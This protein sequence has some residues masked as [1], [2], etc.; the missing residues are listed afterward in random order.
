MKPKSIEPKTIELSRV[1]VEF[2]SFVQRHKER[3]MYPIGVETTLAITQDQN[4][5][6][7]KTSWNCIGGFNWWYSTISQLCHDRACRV[8]TGDLL[9]NGIRMKPETYLGLWRQAK[10]SA[11]AFEQMIERGMLLVA[12]IRKPM[13]FCK[14]MQASES[15]ADK[16]F[17][18][19]L[20]SPHIVKSDDHEIVWRIP[21]NSM[22]S[23]LDY[24]A[25]NRWHD[26]EKYPGEFN[27]SLDI[28]HTLPAANT[29]QATTPAT[30]VVN[31]QTE[32]FSEAA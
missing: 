30:Q 11:I 2:A 3:D 31:E 21:I 29:A 4:A 15:E 12:T 24:I 18:T 13:A 26:Q 17:A 27:N 22:E 9:P 28:E 5:E 25:V 16:A 19:R 7:G 1:V 8:E 20:T 14:V 10:E 6:T 23:L 32:L